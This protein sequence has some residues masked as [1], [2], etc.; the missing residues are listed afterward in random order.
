MFTKNALI[1]VFHKEGII[2]FTQ[3][4]VDLG[5]KIYA[6]GG[7]ARHLKKGGI[8]VI[9]TA[10]F[11]SQAIATQVNR[12]AQ[13]ND[14]FLPVKVQQALSTAFGKSYFGHRVLTLD[15]RVHGGFLSRFNNSDDIS[16]LEEM[17]GVY[18][19]LFCGDFYP[20]EQKISEAG[21]T[22]KSVNEA[23]DIGGPTMLRSAAKG[24]RI[25]IGDVPTRA[26]VLERLQQDGD[27][28]A[29]DRQMLAARA[30]KICALYCLASAR[31]R[32]QG[33]IDGF[34]GNKG[35]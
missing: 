35:S 1:S 32:S 15:Q 34:I 23:T 5:W 17:C 22:Y 6:S 20:L 25:A 16:D 8:F 30:E 26:W 14:H 18:F 33:E 12:I 11:I 27:I 3:G 2:E 13:E 24:L 4:L 28:S 29:M 31:Y 7:T 21:A 9:D 19:D 10:D